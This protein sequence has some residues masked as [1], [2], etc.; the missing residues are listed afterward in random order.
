MSAPVQESKEAY[1]QRLYRRVNRPGIFS[2]ENHIQVTKLDD[3]YAE[4]ELTVV[5]SSLNPRNIVHGG[6][7]FTLMDTVGGMAAITCGK[8]CVTLNSNV[9]FLRPGADTAKIRCVATP[10]KLG[11]TIAVFRTT[12]TDDRGRELAEGTFTYFLLDDRA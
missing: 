8:N 12:L 10:V 7:M 3:N 1:F 11:A 4:G 2:S 5:P 9:S 6:V